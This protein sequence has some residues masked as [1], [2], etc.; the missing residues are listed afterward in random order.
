GNPIP[1]IT[2]YRDEAQLSSD[3]RLGRNDSGQYTFVASNVIGKS[4]CTTNITVE[5]TPIFECPK[6]YEGR[7]NDI[8]LSDCLV[9]ASPKASVTWKKDGNTVN[10]VHNFKRNDSG[11]YV[12]T[13]MNKHGTA[14]HDLTVNVLYGPEIHLAKTLEVKTGNDVSLNCTAIGNP[15]PEVRWTFRGQFKT[16]GS[17]Q[18]ILKITNAKS[19][20]GG[21]Y[22]CNATNKLGSKTATVLLKIK[23]K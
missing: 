9:M 15:E 11:S 17:R 21:Q 8:S 16:N 5:Y 7:E 18:A 13:A 20:H 10:A 2:W 19:D 4:S 3:M 12:L 23:G 14:Q 1:K 6:E 22:T